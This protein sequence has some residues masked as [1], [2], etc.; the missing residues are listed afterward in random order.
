MN[1]NLAWP[2]PLQPTTFVELLQW[3][4]G[5]QMERT[6][7][8][9]LLDGENTAISF[10]YA[11]LHQQASIIAAAIQAKI[12]VGER[13]LLLYQPGMEYI[14]A[15][16]G[17]LY[18]GVIAI[19]A[20]L[21]APKRPPLR[22]QAIVQDAQPTL[23]LSTEALYK[24]LQRQ[25]AML[26]T[27]AEIDWL[28]TDHDHSAVVP[29]SFAP[30]RIEGN[31][32]AF[33]QYTSGSTASPKGVMVS[34]ANLLANLGNMY[35]YLAVAEENSGVS[36]LPPYHD[37]GLIGGILLPIY[38]GAKMTLMSP[39]S[40]LQRP[41]RWLEAISRTRATVSVAPDFAYALCARKI[42]A[43]QRAGLDLSNWRIALVGAEPVHATTLADFS[44]AFAECQFKPEAF[45]PCY[46]LAEA[47]LMAASKLP[48]TPPIVRNFDAV[49]LE[50]HKVKRAA[51]HSAANIRSMRSLVS[52][53]QSVIGQ[54]IVIVAPDTRKYCNS[55]EVGE[56]WVHG[57]SVAQGYWKQPETSKET[58]QAYVAE[59]GEGPF[60]RTGDLGFF[61]QGELYITGRLKD[62][63]ILH[64]RNHYP[65]D[66]ELTAQGSHS[67]L[68]PGAGAAFSIEK[69]NTEKLVIAHELERH[70]R[71]QEVD[72]E[73]VI[74]AIRNAI[75][76][77]HELDVYCVALLK[78]GS[79]PKTSSGKI[80]RRACREAFLADELQP[81]VVSS[82]EQRRNELAHHATA[83]RSLQEELLTR[84]WQDVLGIERVGVFDSFVD[85]GGDSL[86]AAQ[87]ISR[88]RDT[89]QLELPLQDLLASPTI[90]EQAQ[91]IEQARLTLLNVPLPSI[92]AT[93][94]TTTLFPLSYA[95]ERMWF[96][97]Q[98][99]PGSTGPRDN[100]PIAVR[101]RGS[102]EIDALMQGFEEIMRRH[103]ILRTTFNTVDEMQPFTE[104]QTSMHRLSFDHLNGTVF[105]VIHPYQQSLAVGEA[106]DNTPIVSFFDL[107][108]WLEPQQ[109][110]EVARLLREEQY[111]VF[112]LRTGPLL[113]IKIVQLRQDEWV[114]L[115]N[116]HHII[117]DGW[118]IGIV[119]Q[120]LFTCYEAFVH[121][122]PVS[123]PELPIQ[124]G[125][126]ALWQRQWLQGEALQRQLAYWQKQLAG[127]PA[128][129]K[130]PT[131][132]PRPA[133]RSYAGKCYSFTFSRELSQDIQVLSRGEGVTLFMVLLTA[134]TILLYLH[135]GQSDI[136][137]GSMLA[138]RMRTET[139]K[140]LGLF[141]N[142][143][144]LR[145]RI[146][147]GD[148]TFR[149]LLHHVR[150]TTLAAYTYQDAPF[151]YVVEQSGLQPDPAYT[152]LFQVMLTLQDMSFGTGLE[153]IEGLTLEPLGDEWVVWEAEQAPCDLELHI[154]EDMHGGL[155]GNLYY[156]TE[157]FVE[158][159]IQNLM[160]HF[161]DI[162]KRAVID[163]GERVQ[164][165]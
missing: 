98:T 110:Q 19:P 54:E 17:C 159:T 13:A 56:I 16:L 90:A 102:V 156:S 111:C 76:E 147:H 116:I 108:A 81:V 94:R 49:S 99:I 51:D 134:Y 95:Q 101:L 77:Q 30:P 112:D 79:I 44:A 41:L 71:H 146:E 133:V 24:Q 161:Q 43:E 113:H 87:I 33:L 154:L 31:T 21:P 20:Y 119:I 165:L 109:D 68:S 67:L 10:T 39:L 126:Y 135:S 89:F 25:F 131:D 37:M 70:Y 58:F 11:Q 127:V 138:D 45:Q 64:G 128:L 32:L 122:R 84:I 85:L 3:R 22:L 74:R 141:I 59:S 105:Q 36:W 40:F 66:L 4:A 152:T 139:E 35:R 150:A 120:E 23:V 118:S 53:G 96:F 100:I 34:H 69:D 2:I 60:L 137:V 162:L 7:L 62:L 38:S 27:L 26:P 123:L 145:M 80:Q 106:A 6:A 15:F 153:Q 28:L 163:P 83:P 48:L 12:A 160:E 149:E 63:I 155:R 78:P 103:D 97:E 57:S 9:F 91:Q 125:D 121:Q 42:P 92:E 93:S 86:Q 115:L 73:E 29:A 1:S 107:T 55:T 144:A 142:P 50:V 114:L 18:A 82:Q 151:Q 148:I 46:G 143:I 5:H 117:F 104:A 164:D 61:H 75:W 124:Y 129:L 140:L 47:T 158:N 88:I 65:Q 52:C 157:L 136:V 14:T 132:F 72:L 130:L 8:T